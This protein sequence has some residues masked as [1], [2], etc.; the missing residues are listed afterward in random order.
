MCRDVLWIPGNSR[1]DGERCSEEGKIQMNGNTLS[2]EKWLPGSNKTTQICC[3]RESTIRLQKKADSRLNLN[4]VMFTGG[5]KPWTLSHCSKN[6]GLQ[7][8]LSKQAAGSLTGLLGVSTPRTMTRDVWCFPH[9]QILFLFMVFLSP[10]QVAVW[11]TRGSTKHVVGILVYYDYAFMKQYL[12]TV[13][14]LFQLNTLLPVDAFTLAF[15]MK[16]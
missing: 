4:V 6:C 8:Y 3:G 1:G 10:A 11:F 9:L 13:S 2:T 16:V 7:M 12:K 15:K 14:K 5:N